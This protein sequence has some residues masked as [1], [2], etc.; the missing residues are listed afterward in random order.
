MHRP[1]MKIDK[2]ILVRCLYNLDNLALLFT[3]RI[4]SGAVHVCRAL[5]SLCAGADKP[6]RVHFI[7]FNI[8]KPAW[9][10]YFLLQR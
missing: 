7:Y 6:R 2:S 3:R 9:A 1:Y 10:V 5:S 4:K 8:F